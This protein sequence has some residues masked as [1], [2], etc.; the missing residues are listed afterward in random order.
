MLMYF[1]LFKNN[2]D[3]FVVQQKVLLFISVENSN[4]FEGK[5]ILSRHNDLCETRNQQKQIDMV[6]EEV[7]TKCDKD[8]CPMLMKRGIP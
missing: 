2:F 5:K 6:V 4:L 7:S 1:Q 8:L 3:I